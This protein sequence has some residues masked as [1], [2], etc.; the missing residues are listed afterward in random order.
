[1][2][3]SPEAI[4]GAMVE[5]SGEE[6]EEKITDLVSGLDN[7]SRGFGLLIA[8]VIASEMYA[9]YGLGPCWDVAMLLH[10]VC[11]LA[12]LVC[13]GGVEVFSNPWVDPVDE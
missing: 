12:Y 6:A 2:R 10:F 7:F 3:V 13:G 9:K 5:F 1:V 4:E 8:P 11:F